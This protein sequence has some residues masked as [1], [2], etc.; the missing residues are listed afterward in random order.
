[1]TL[2][3]L[4]EIKGLKEGEDPEDGEAQEEGVTF[5]LWKKTEQPPHAEPVFD[6]VPSYPVF[7][8]VH[9]NNL[10]ACSVLAVFMTNR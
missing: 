9:H 8:V 3:L 10:R 4:Q 6:E 7:D 2:C 5:N 1:M